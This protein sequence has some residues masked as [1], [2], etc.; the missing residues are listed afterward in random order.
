MS[1]KSF[2]ETL[3]GDAAKVFK[4]IGSTKAQQVITT[5]ETLAESVADAVD[6]GLA[7]L[8]PLITSWTQEIFKAEALATAAGTQ[9]GSGVLKAAA[10]ANAVVP[11]VTAFATQNKLVGTDIN[12]ANTA[13]VAFLK[14]LGSPAA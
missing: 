5:T 7:S 3:G 10:V 12:A 14:A 4:W 9:T 6:P 2:F 8:N 11:Q 13:L 1:V